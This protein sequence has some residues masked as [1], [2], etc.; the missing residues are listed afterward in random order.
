MNTLSRRHFIKLALLA[1][2]ATGCSQVIDR[3]TQPA[4]PAA[5]NPPD[6]TGRHPIAHLLNRATFGPRPGQIAEVQ[7]VGRTAWI[8]AQLDYESINDDTVA[9]R[10][11]R[12]DTLRMKPAD[13]LGFTGSANRR[14]VRDELAAMTLLRAVYSQRQLYEVMVNFWSDHFNI[15]HFKSDTS[16]LKT[17]DD[18][19]VI[20]PH[21]LGRFGDLLKASA[22]SPAMLY[23]LDNVENR[24][25]S[26]NENYAREIMELHTLGVDGGYTEDDIREVARCFSGWTMTRQGRFTF[27]PEWHSPGDKRVLGEII[28]SDQPKDEGDRVLEILIAH[29]STAR[30]ISTKLVRRFVA[31]DPPQAIVDAC[32]DA[33]RATNGDLRAVCRALLNHP[34]FDAAPPKLR[35]PFELVVSLMRLTNARYDGSVEVINRLDR[36]AHRPFSWSMPDGYPDTAAD[37]NGNLLHR[38]NFGLDFFDNVIPGL[39]VNLDDLKDATGQAEE[40]A[41]FASLA[42]HL[43]GGSHALEQ[44]HQLAD[45]IQHQDDFPAV[46]G[47]LAASPVFQWR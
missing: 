35:R 39:Q 38:W 23:Y 8:E 25:G 11:R 3:H 2:S 33:W 42:Q 47:L 20:R 46:L 44:T 41:I 21:A 34:G 19:E 28:R 9:L 32:A 6:T 18:R 26:L 10:L 15:Y 5:L 31:D 45:F 27:V 16:S 1:T 37:W 7:A 24:S 30:H 17:V 36:M 14:H 22:H 43:L 29:P 40:H 12:Y 13:L 4:M